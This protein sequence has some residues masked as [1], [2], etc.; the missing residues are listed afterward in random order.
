[1]AEERK[2]A[3]GDSASQELFKFSPVAFWRTLEA[4]FVKPRLLA[5]RIGEQNWAGMLPPLK[6]V[7]G[8]ALLMVA[9]AWL[10]G[11]T[12]ELR[13]MTVSNPGV[14]CSAVTLAAPF[15]LLQT[16]MARKAA[17]PEARRNFFDSLAYV[18]YIYC[19]LAG[20]FLLLGVIQIPF[21]LWMAKNTWVKAI[22]PFVFFLP[23]LAYY[24]FGFFGS[25]MRMLSAAF[26]IPSSTAVLIF[27]ASLIPS[28]GLWFAAALLPIQW[29]TLAIP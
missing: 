29:P 10:M 18:F 16:L 24:S 4:Y 7:A 8:C 12:S 11:T 5:L 17:A 3:L 1:M 21:E 2:T 20:V 6:F 15:I 28:L 13:A 26:G 19:Y 22:V 14:V 23:L 25:P 27:F 9:E